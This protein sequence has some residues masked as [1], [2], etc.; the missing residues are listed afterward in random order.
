MSSR[1]SELT[2]LEMKKVNGGRPCGDGCDP[3][4]ECCYRT[5][6]GCWVRICPYSPPQ[7]NCI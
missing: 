1:S 2:K 7:C 6:A 5:Q 4:E 3:A